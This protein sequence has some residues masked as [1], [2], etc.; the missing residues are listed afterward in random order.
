MGTTR[1]S[2]QFQVAKEFG[3]TDNVI[4]RL[5]KR[6][7]YKCAANLIENLDKY[8]SEEEEIAATPRVSD[9]RELV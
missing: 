7:R 5:L 4:G 9:Q 8:E 3:Y 2:I 1:I 6:K